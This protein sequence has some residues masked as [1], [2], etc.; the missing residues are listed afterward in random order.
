[1]ADK[2]L[3]VKSQKLKVKA[4]TQ[5]SKVVAPKTIKDESETPVKVVRET[6]GTIEVDVIGLNGKATGKIDLP[7]EIFGAKVNPVLMAQAVRVYLANQRRGTASTKTRGEVAASTRKIY[8]QKGTGRARHGAL[9]APLF[10]GGGI[11]FGPK[12]KDFSM[13]LPKKMKRGA[14]FSALTS[15]LQAK[16]IMVIDGQKAQKTKEIAQLLKALELR[17]KKKNGKV[18]VVASK[19]D[20]VLGRATRNIEGVSVVAAGSLTTYDC[21]NNKHLIFARNAVDA[22]KT[23]YIK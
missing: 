20:A 4:A 17:G 1:M 13:N 16:E 12:P 23:L 22:L 11:S 21:L 9:T 19:E 10:V 14:L 6:R 18:V 8:R 7:K 15:K 3:K 5:K 2:E